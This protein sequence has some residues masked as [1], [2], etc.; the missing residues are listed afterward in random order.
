[1]TNMFSTIQEKKNTNHGKQEVKTT[2]MAA[3]TFKCLQCVQ[4]SVLHRYHM[5]IVTKHGQ[6]IRVSE[7][8]DHWLNG[9]VALPG[10]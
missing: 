5:R 6:K 1:M 3:R 4:A 10:I 7:P 2:G 9:P 8:R